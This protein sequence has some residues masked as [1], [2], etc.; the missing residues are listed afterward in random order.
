MIRTI[1][2]AALCAACLGLSATAL[3]AHAT[4]E[5]RQAPANSYY[6][7]VLRTPHG[8]S[9][10]PT[11]AVRLQIPE[12]VMGAKPQ[13]KPGW[14]LETVTEELAEPITDGHGNTI[15]SRVSEI[16]WTGGRLLDAHYDEFAVQVRL[17]DTPGET[18]YFAA[19][20]ECEEG[21]D[22]WVE[23]PAEGQSARDLDYPAPSVTLTAPN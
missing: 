21:V 22:R 1:V 7:A 17:P 13:P 9:G 4:L 5:V 18:L 16:H 8:C 15:T 11:I 10:S 2:S 3:H 19:I 12:G 20:Q 23:I 14:E 6:K